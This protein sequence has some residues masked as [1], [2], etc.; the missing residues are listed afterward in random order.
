VSGDLGGRQRAVG[1]AVSYARTDIAY[2][3]PSVHDARTP[4]FAAIPR[5]SE[6]RRMG[7]DRRASAK[8]LHQ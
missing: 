8:L 1:P 3:L 5:M 6:L 2:F 7:P 4:A